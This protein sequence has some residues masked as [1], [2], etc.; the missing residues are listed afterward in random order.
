MKLL[1]TTLV[2]GFGFWFFI[3]KG[4]G[5]KEESEGGS[6]GSNKLTQLSY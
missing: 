5:I 6:E 2:F 3:Y 4:E 1:F